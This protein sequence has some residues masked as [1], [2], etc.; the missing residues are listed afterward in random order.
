[1]TDAQRQVQDPLVGGRD[2]VSPG[3]SDLLAGPVRK[4]LG[5]SSS[6]EQKVLNKFLTNRIFQATLGITAD[7]EFTL[8]G[9][10]SEIPGNGHYLEVKLAWCRLG[11]I[12][13][14]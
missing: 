3:I 11:C 10:L 5:R 1:M 14:Y 4:I 12:T 9:F 8:S 13:Q 2:G 7:L 6:P